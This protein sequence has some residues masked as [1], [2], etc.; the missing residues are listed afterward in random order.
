MAGRGLAAASFVASLAARVH[1]VSTGCRSEID[2][3][4]PWHLYFAETAPARATPV[5]LLLRLPAGVLV[6]LIRSATDK[7]CAIHE[8]V[9]ARRPRASWAATEASAAAASVVRQ[10]L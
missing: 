10:S 5:P 1:S 3:E 9:R 6:P 7:V 8:A 2:G 4:G